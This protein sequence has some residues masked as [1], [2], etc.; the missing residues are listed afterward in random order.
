MD[1]GADYKKPNTFGAG[2]LASLNEAMDNLDKDIKG[3]MLTGKLSGAGPEQYI[4]NVLASPQGAIT[5]E[6]ERR[7]YEMLL[8]S[9]MKPV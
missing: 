3:L 1:N 7:T 8:A 5:G 2:A 4:D 6:K 9:P